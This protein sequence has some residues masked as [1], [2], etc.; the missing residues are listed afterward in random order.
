MRMIHASVE[1]LVSPFSMLY[2]LCMA[3]YS[4]IRGIERMLFIISHRPQ[5]LYTRVVSW[6]VIQGVS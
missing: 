2:M 6:N 5:P 3:A 1:F 4:A